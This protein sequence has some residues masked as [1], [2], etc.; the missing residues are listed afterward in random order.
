LEQFVQQQPENAA[1]NFYYAIVLSKRQG[2][3]D[4]V[5][6]ERI[7]S[8]LKKAVA[9]NPQFAE[10]HLELGT[11]YAAHSKFESAAS[12]YQR[13]IAADPQ[14]SEAH[15]RLARIYK[16]LGQEQKAQQEFA[17]Y[18]QIEKTEAAAVDRQRRE[19]QQFIIV[20][21]E[22]PAAR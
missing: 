15:Y 11:L 10:A 22:Q 6:S 2:G 4:Q 7:Q 1:A 19:V 21:K 16:Q 9:I 20:L 8:L 12:S 13:A 14:L 18:R 3:P 5:T 17:A